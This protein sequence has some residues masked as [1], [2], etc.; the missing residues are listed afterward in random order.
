MT[1]NRRQFLNT[2]GAAV[3]YKVVDSGFSLKAAA[4]NDQIGLGFIGVGVR[5]SYLMD[6]FMAIPGVRPIMVADLWDGHLERSRNKTNH[7]IETT[8]EFEKVLA[9]PKVDA[10]VIATPD[11]WHKDLVI[12]A[13]EAGKHVYIEKPMTWSVEEGIEIMETVD[14]TG[15]LLQVGSQDRSSALADKARELVADGTLGQVTMVS[16]SNHRNSAGGAWVWPVPPGA[17]PKTVDW[18]RFLG[19]APKRAWD[20]EIFFRWRCWWDYSGGVATDLFVHLLTELHYI[21]NVK[22]PKT[23]VSQGGLYY[24]RDGRDVPDVMHSIYEY[25]GF[26]ANM[27]V[28]LANAFPLKRQLIM[29]TKATLDFSSYDKL[30]V[31]PEKPDDG[32]VTYG[33]TGWPEKLK[34]EYFLAHGYTAEGKPKE[35]RS[36]PQP[37]EIKLP[38]NPSHQERFIISLREGKPSVESAEEGHNAAGAAHIANIAYRKVRKVGWDAATARVQLL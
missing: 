16:M 4:A 24:W 38:R 28:H 1:S 27:Y 19:R 15:K 8:K 36:K 30:V 37:K 26:I 12:A 32:V 17:S 33:V 11:H 21:M 6:K 31:Y 29:G 35:P 9:N 25:D 2:A 13:L 3:I 34:A 10:V 18:E 14:R 7:S 23:V 5:G 22:A 20:P